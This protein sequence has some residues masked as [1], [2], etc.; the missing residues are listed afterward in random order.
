MHVEHQA[1]ELEDRTRIRTI[2][3]DPGMLLLN[4]D[5]LV[6]TVQTVTPD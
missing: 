3:G 2:L 1:A 6:R 5:W 4:R